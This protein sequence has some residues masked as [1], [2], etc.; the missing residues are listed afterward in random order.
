MPAIVGNSKRT[1]QNQEVKTI[2][3]LPQKKKTSL[4]RLLFQLTLAAAS[5]LAISLPL[6]S[7]IA[8]SLNPI[9]PEGTVVRIDGSSS[10]AT[11]NETLKDHIETTYP[12]TKVIVGYRGT[13]KALEALKAGQIDLAAIGRPLTAAEKAD[14]FLAHALSRRKIA[15]VV[16]ADNPFEG[17]LSHEQFARIFR[18]EIDDW[19]EIGGDRRPIRFVDRP[20]ASDTRQALRIYPIFQDRT[21]ASGENALQLEKD[22]TAALIAELDDNAI[23]YTIADQALD[24][25][26]LRILLMHNAFVTETSYPFSQP[27]Y[28]AYRKD[29]TSAAVRS[30]LGLIATPD[31]ERV[32]E[33]AKAG[34]KTAISAGLLALAPDFSR[35]PSVPSATIEENEETTSGIVSPAPEESPGNEGAVAIAPANSSASQP[36]ELP[37]ETTIDRADPTEEAEETEI[38][39]AGSTEEAEDEQDDNNSL[40]WWLLAFVGLLGLVWLWLNKQKATS[41][42]K[43]TLGLPGQPPPVAL[44]PTPAEPAAPVAPPEPPKVEPPPVAPVAPVAPPEPP[45]VETPP[46]APVAPV[47]PPEPPKVETP[48]VAPVTPVAPPE[49]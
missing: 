30:F 34:E 11:V 37:E 49:P 24:R 18:G 25:P 15:V 20:R 48:P 39:P 14:G 29:N 42:V 16:S 36:S 3:M 19:S 45:K 9:V 12:D 27:R 38:A 46:V 31:G 2:A 44:A 28:Y 47:A 17:S 7:A 5:A 22:S 33:S 4:A 21:F 13:E 40:V 32:I 10:M 41:F 35:K 23:G 1:T 43:Q 6:D 26:E 8:Q